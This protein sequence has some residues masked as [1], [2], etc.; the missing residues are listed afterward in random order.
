MVKLS[1]TPIVLKSDK[2]TYAISILVTSLITIGFLLTSNGELIHF[3]IIPTFFSG[4]IIGLDLI[5]WLRGRLDVF[6]PVGFLGLFGY[7]FFFIAPLLQIYWNYG[8]SYVN[9]PEDWKVWLLWL[10]TINF[11][12]LIIY[13]LLRGAILKIKPNKKEINFFWK[14]NPKRLLTVSIP[15]LFL[16]FLLQTYIYFSYGGITGYVDTYTSRDGGFEG[17]GFLFMV[18]ESFP[19]IFLIVF[20]HFFQ[21]SKYK[22]SILIM[23]IIFIIFFVLKLYF[24]GLRGSRSNTLWGIIWAVGLIHFFIKPIK[25]KVIIIGVIFMMG[26]IFF[27]GVYKGAGD[28]VI[29][30]I[31]SDKSFEAVTE[32]TGRGIDTVLLGDLARTN[33]QAFILY[34]LIEHSDNYKLALG[35]SYIGDLSILI[36]KRVYPTRPP[37]KVKEGTE[38]I[39]GEG[40]YNPNGYISSRIYGLTGEFM[41]NFGYIFAPLVFIIWTYLVT[42][43]RKSLYTLQ[44][45]D[46][47]L[48]LYP[49]L[50]VVCFLLLV[51]DLDNLVFSIVKNFLIPL[52]IVYISKEKVICQRTQ[53]DK[54]IVN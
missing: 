7:H 23:I 43:V 51:Q 47:R 1:S 24:G 12:G 3:F 53:E 36:P 41:L 34:R 22:N 31:T 8:M 48:Y 45:K 44:H 6:D 33:T 13:R 14:L 19:I 27:Y 54:A 39:R 4:I 30:V 29:D 49:F 26:F 11:I 40:S 10:S 9:E 21:K 5:D 16:M 46:A 52:L 17:M 2:L 32:E 28:D 38:I 50:V 20:I 42:K 18:A 15:L 37:T 35:R 25:K